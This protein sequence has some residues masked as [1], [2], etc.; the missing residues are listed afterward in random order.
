MQIGG[1]LTRGLLCS[2][3]TVETR[4]ADPRGPEP[5]ALHL[6]PRPFRV[7]VVNSFGGNF[8]RMPMPWIAHPAP[9]HLRH[10]LRSGVA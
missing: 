9:R 4:T 2:I 7:S 3:Q 10:A 5:S 1:S 6:G 8:V